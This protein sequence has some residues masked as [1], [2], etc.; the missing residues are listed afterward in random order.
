VPF[1][2]DGNNLLG[3][4][5][6]EGAAHAGDG[7]EEVVRRVC[8]FCRRRGASATLVFDGQP[9]RRERD[10]QALG[11]VEIRYPRL[12]SDA[13]TLI[14]EVVDGAT[15]PESWTVVTSDKPLYSYVR[16]RGA[17][18]MRAHE[19]NAVW[20]GLQ[21]GVPARG[22][23]RRRTEPASPREK[24]EHETD[25]EGWLRRFERR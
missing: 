25:V 16:T 15:S 14:R 21:V 5:R 20:R 2:I 1:L 22:G 3:S 24:P 12:G 7:R 10:D 6:A 9:L 4:W 23:R 18:V 19:W 8:D 13:D 11:R 17:R